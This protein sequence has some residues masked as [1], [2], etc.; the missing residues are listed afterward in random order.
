M[1]DSTHLPCLFRRVFLQGCDQGIEQRNHRSL[2]RVGNR[3]VCK[4]TAG[5][6]RCGQG[7]QV[8][9]GEEPGE[10]A[11]DNVSGVAS[12]REQDLPAQGVGISADIP[13]GGQGNG[14]IAARVTVRHRVDIDP[15]K[16]VG[17]GHNPLIA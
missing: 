5:L 10:E 13:A 15:V 1:T 16:D 3:P 8:F 2:L 11:G 12:G 14:E 17:P 7:R 9:A 6:G 4:V